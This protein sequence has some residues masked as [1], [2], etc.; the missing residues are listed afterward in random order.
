LNC[1]IICWHSLRNHFVKTNVSTPKAKFVFLLDLKNWFKRTY[2]VYLKILTDTTT[3]RII[4]I[5][6]HQIVL[7]G[8]TSLLSQEPSFELLGGFVNAETAFELLDKQTVDVVITD[9][10]MPGIQGE[11][12]V[13]FCKSKFPLTKV[14][15]LSMHDE[16]A[17]I[18]HLIDVG[19]DGYLLKMA[20]K[21]EIIASIK[22]V[23]SGVKHFSD[24]VVQSL[25][26][27]K[28]SSDSINPTLKLLTTREIEIVKLIANGLSSK[29]IGE[30]LHISPRTVE[31]HRA[32]ILKKIDST[33]VA[34][35]IRFAFENGLVD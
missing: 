12:V 1:Q 28:Q 11:Q 7:D 4:L 3:I 10:D 26:Q 6:D 13:R 16:R 23:H 2:I 8:L 20:G 24:D 14:M 18:K 29:E 35:I 5:D 34:G 17:I 21:E 33:G 27:N 31:T 30:Q 25:I 19:A 15:V 22:L 32:N 9:L